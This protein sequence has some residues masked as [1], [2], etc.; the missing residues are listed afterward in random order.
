ME[1]LYGRDVAIGNQL[2][3]KAPPVPR[4]VFI[5]SILVG[6]KIG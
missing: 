6:V 1:E 4:Y 3:A 2:T 5:A